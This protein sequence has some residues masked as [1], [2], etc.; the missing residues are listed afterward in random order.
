VA[1]SILQQMDTSPPGSKIAPKAFIIIYY[2]ELGK[3]YVF[4]VNYKVSTL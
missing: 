2:V 3:P 1:F 4:L